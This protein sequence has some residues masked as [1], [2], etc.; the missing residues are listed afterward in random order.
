LVTAFTAGHSIS[1]CASA[2]GWISLPSGPVEIAIAG[3]VVIAAALNL[4]PRSVETWRGL[5]TVRPL[6]A[7]GFGVL[8]GFGFASVL[9]DVGLPASERVIALLSF[10]AGIELAQIAL[11]A[12]ALPIL[13]ACASLLH[14]RG[15]E[16]AV[17][18]SGS[19]AIAAIALVWVVERAAAL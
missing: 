3:S 11:V 8:H 5:T 4:A 9:G 6:V 15:R 17:A 7:L 18:L 16:R 1:L 14:A 19:L 10:N 13:A 2:L 12:L